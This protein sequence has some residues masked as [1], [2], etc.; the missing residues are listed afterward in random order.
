MAIPPTIP[1]KYPAPNKAKEKPIGIWKIALPPGPVN[2]A[3][4]PSAIKRKPFVKKAT[5]L[6]KIPP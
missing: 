3:L 6:A 1:I 4:A 5:T 2:H